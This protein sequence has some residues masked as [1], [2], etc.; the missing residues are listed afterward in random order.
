MFVFGV[1]LVRNESIEDN[2]ANIN[3]ILKLVVLAYISCVS[4]QLYVYT[5]L[6]IIRQIEVFSIRFKCLISL[7]AKR[8]EAHIRNG[9]P[10]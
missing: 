6:L 5:F 3:E 10:M 4:A 1:F 7:S 9:Q 8:K 2:S